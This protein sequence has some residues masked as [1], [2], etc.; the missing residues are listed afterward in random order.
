MKLF[1]IYLQ[2]LKM[3]RWRLVA[4]GFFL[5]PPLTFAGAYD[6][7]FKAL[8]LDHPATVRALLARGFD[9]NTPHPQGAPALLRALQVQSFQV[10][11]VLAA[12]P[13]TRVEARNAGGETALM[14]AA[15]RGQEALVVQL[16]ARGAS[17]NHRGWTPLHYAAT[18]GHARV[19]AFLVGAHADLN[20]ESPNGSTP[21]MMA[22]MY[23]NAATV[24]FLL[25]AGADP[26]VRNDQGLSAEDFA[27]RAGRE[28]ALRLI[29]QV[30]GR[31]PG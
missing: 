27:V 7:F 15:L 30:L 20:A 10:A 9:P 16:V 8:E 2:F 1:R 6:D 25:E 14:L 22:A 13:H 11:A 17:V 26:E 4:I 12:D 21:L 31:Q 18:G 19:A 28:D 29:R 23:G 24:K 5:M 3:V